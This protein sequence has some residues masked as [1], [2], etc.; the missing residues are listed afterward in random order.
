M[1][2]AR[3]RLL[4][5]REQQSNPPPPATTATTWVKVN[6]KLTKET[7]SKNYAISDGCFTTV[8]NVGL[9][10]D[11]VF[12]VGVLIS[13]LLCYISLSSEL[14]N[15]AHG[16]NPIYGGVDCKWGCGGQNWPI[17]TSFFAKCPC[18]YGFGAWRFFLPSFS[19]FLAPKIGL[20]WGHS[21]FTR[22]EVPLCQFWGSTEEW[23]NS[24]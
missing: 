13:T 14:W 17:W 1:I 9:V 15:I 16:G 6:F 23:A 19:L 2:A 10:M 24:I 4:P 5:A 20:F 18:P 12:L 7:K 11:R 21:H 3:R 22:F 8:L